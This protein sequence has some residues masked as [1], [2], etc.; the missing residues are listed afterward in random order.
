METRRRNLF[1]SEVDENTCITYVVRF[2]DQTACF[3]LIWAIS[4]R[5]LTENSC[6][7]DKVITKNDSP[8]YLT[9]RRNSTMAIKRNTL[10]RRA[11]FLRR[12]V[13]R[14]KSVPTRMRGCGEGMT[15][16]QDGATKRGSFR[17]ARPSDGAVARVARSLG[18]AGA[19]RKAH[20]RGH[21]RLSPTRSLGHAR[22]TKRGLSPHALARR[23]SPLRRSESAR[24][25]LAR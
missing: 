17:V 20:G 7:L 12:A 3:P 19:G 5:A 18:H 24:T 9:V 6:P 22:A 2:C 1:A 11:S 15:V 16:A 8:V 10:G 23:D 21:A 13:G 25:R 4:A 14:C